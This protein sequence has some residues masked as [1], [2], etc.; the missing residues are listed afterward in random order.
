[1]VEYIEL[2]L[3]KYYY[4]LRMYNVRKHEYLQLKDR[5]D[6]PIKGVNVGNV[7]SSNNQAN[8]AVERLI[9]RKVTLEQLADRNRLEIA[10]IT[11]D[12]HLGDMIKKLDS[13]EKE[14]VKKRYYDELTLEEIGKMIGLTRHAVDQ[15]LKRLLAKM[16][17]GEEDRW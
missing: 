17:K 3:K 7:P 1:M 10:R 4:H 6:N 5:L 11:T 12:E 9:L 16:A 2:L 15:R 8:N 14:I 13:V